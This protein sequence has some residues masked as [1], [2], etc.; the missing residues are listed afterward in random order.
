MVFFLFAKTGQV[1]YKTNILVEIISEKEE[2]DL[3]H[4]ILRL[5]FQNK[6]YYVKESGSSTTT[7]SLK[8]QEICTPIKSSKILNLFPFYIIFKRNLEVL[9]LGQSLRQSVH[10]AVGE[11]LRDAFQLVY[12][13]VAFTWDNVKLYS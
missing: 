9:S 10:H 6:D 4:V 7:R 1:F 3:V 13:N 12:P 5:K 2:N 11:S 8:C